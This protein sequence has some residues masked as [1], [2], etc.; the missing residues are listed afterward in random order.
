[1]THINKLLKTFEFEGLS[2]LVNSLFPSLKYAL[3][4]VALSIS[5]MSVVTYKV[6]G[7]DVLATIAFVLVMVVEILSGLIASKI[8]K[9]KPYWISQS[10]FNKMA[11]Y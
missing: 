2:G 6:F 9:L 3:S 5:A 1:M 10:L 7:L 4:P 8:R 11:C